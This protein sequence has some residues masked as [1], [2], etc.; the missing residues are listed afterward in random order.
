[1]KNH[2]QKI[3]SAPV[4][5]LVAALLAGCQASATRQYPPG[6]YPVPNYPAGTGPQ[7]SGGS[8]APSGQSSQSPP[9]NSRSSQHVMESMA[10]GARWGGMLAGPFGHFGALG[11][12]LI[13]AL[14]GMVT[15][16][17]EEERV[18]AQ[19]NKEAQKDQQLEAMIEKELERQRELE[20]QVLGTAAPATTTPAAGKPPAPAGARQPAV[21][22]PPKP[23]RDK[24]EVASINKPVQPAAAP[25]P[26]KNVEVRDMNGDGVPDLWIYYNPQ[27]PGEIVRQEESTKGDG[28][29]DAWSYFKDGKLQRREI[30]A[31]G[32]GQPTTVYHYNDDKLAREE[33]DESGQ[34]RMTYRATYDNGRLAKVERDTTGR[35]RPDSW[36]Y[37]DTAQESEIILKEERDLN[38]DGVADIWTYYEN[39]RV[40]R[41]DVS[42]AGLEIL[43]KQEQLPNSELRTVSLPG[44]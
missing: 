37:Y 30:D 41:R 2:R 10:E 20:A 40:A 19:V 32:Q 7:Q 31:R 36:V 21:P 16:G 18:T 39:G 17:Q 12:I 1:M 27:K 6:T 24:I 3:A 34:G 38:G 44:N 42:A 43:A 29:V 14:Y 13:G 26:F 23:N 22:P 8:N 11:G 25:A 9:R 35:G 5:F 4:L 15:V 33:R 28:R